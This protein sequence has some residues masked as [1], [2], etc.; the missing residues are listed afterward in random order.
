MGLGTYLFPRLREAT[1]GQLWRTTEATNRH[2]FMRAVA[3]GHC[4][5]DHRMS[6]HPQH[7]ARRH[8]Q[9][10]PLAMCIKP[11]PHEVSGPRKGVGC[12]GLGEAQGA[13]LSRGGT[14]GLVSLSRTHRAGPGCPCQFKH[15]L[16][17]AFLNGREDTPCSCFS[18][19]LKL[20]RTYP[21]PLSPHQQKKANSKL[22]PHW[23]ERPAPSGISL[24]RVS[25]CPPPWEWR[26]PSPRELG[27][28]G[29][30]RGILTSS[31]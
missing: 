26:R 10:V 29:G 31:R 7:T 27:R 24:L 13:S 6:A 15:F 28:E 23:L 4:S 30:S 25:P 21:V 2:L 14:V 18:F 8:P 16:A 1:P 9:K 22:W 11:T 12:E 20:I 17:P 5:S 19:V 3:G